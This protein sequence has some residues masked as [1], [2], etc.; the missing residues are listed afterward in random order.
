MNQLIAIFLPSVISLTH[1]QKSKNNIYFI[2]IYLLYV[3]FINTLSYMILI[4][5]FKNPNFIFTNQFTIKYI[6]LS[7]TIAYIL[8]IICN[9]V[10]SNIKINIRIQKNEK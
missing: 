6:F 5:V 8:P 10:T 2:K 4:Y 3:L 1:Y 9:F 7:T